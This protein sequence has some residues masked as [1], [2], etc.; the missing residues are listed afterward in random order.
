M[1]PSHSFVIP[2]IPCRGYCLLDIIDEQKKTT[3]GLVLPDT[4]Q[5]KQ[6]KG[7]VL[8]IGLAPFLPNGNIVE[9]E[10]KKEDIVWFKR[11]GG[12][13]VTEKNKKYMLVPSTALLG[14]VI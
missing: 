10:I 14:K 11:F 13:E 12:E 3:G 8:S 1:I 2:I 6:A 5:E 9:W 4:S 7:R